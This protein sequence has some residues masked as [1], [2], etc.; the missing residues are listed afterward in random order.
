MLPLYTLVGLSRI[1]YGVQEAACSSSHAAGAR[2]LRTK[3]TTGVA[4]HAALLPGP[5]YLPLIASWI[6]AFKKRS[7]WWSAS[8][9][10]MARVRAWLIRSFKTGDHTEWAT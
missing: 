7:A 2:T 4:A 6:T 10:D 5:S 1:G 3:G 9:T 8:S